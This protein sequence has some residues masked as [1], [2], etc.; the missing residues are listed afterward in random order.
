MLLAAKVMNSY[1]NTLGCLSR[2]GLDGYRRAVQARTA[3]TTP[4]CPSAILVANLE[5]SFTDEAG[6]L[7]KI[8]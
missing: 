1:L 2:Q 6:E 7:F 5:S 8:C 3:F 4:S